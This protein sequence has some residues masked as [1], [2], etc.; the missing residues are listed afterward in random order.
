MDEISSRAVVI[1]V[2]VFV[3]LVILTVILFEFNQIQ[4]I[5]KDVGQ[6]DISFENSLDELDKYRDTNNIFS[7]LDV[8]NTVK[9]Y[10]KNLNIKVCVMSDGEE[11][12]DDNINVENLDYKKEYVP[13]FDETTNIYKILFSER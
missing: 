7:G 2:S 1:G 3:T 4:N 12:C 11:Q 9:K 8:R 10:K 13:S 6:T 5:Y